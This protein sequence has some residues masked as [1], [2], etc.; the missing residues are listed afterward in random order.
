MR[1]DK[2]LRER[3]AR[4]DTYEHD[5]FFKGMKNVFRN[6]PFIG[7]CALYILYGTT[8][9]TIMASIPYF[10]KDILQM[11]K[12][13]EFIVI[14][15]IIGVFLTAPFWYRAVPRLGLKKVTLWGGTILALMGIPFIFVPTGIPGLIV[16]ILV[17]FAAGLA[18]GAIVSMYMPLLSSA[19]DIGTLKNGKRQEGIYNGVFAFVGSFGA[20][21]TPGVTWIVRL[22]S[23]YQPLQNNTPE[24]LMGLRMMMSVIP[25]VLMFI[26]LITFYK[27]YNLTNKK[28]EE[29][30]RLLLEQNL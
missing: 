29:N 5:P 22:L 4:I 6:K 13:G 23:G 25:M 26:G 12:E 18:D 10:V 20:I 19:I 28:I 27:F 30:S 11:E 15:Y 16:T 7:F 8:M 17:L 3:R 9:G 1:E 24:Q 21:I 14:A 2:D